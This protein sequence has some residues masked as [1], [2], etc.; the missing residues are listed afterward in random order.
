[1][2]RPKLRLWGRTNP[3]LSW[4]FVAVRWWVFWLPDAE[5]DGGVEEFEGAA[6]GGGGLGEHVGGGV[7]AGEADPIA[8]Q[9]GQVSEQVLV[10]AGR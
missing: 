7:G 1:M 5:W 9:G 8:G 2:A 4:G 3:R 6:L 10:G